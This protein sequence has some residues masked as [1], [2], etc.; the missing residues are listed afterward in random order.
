MDGD[1]AQKKMAEAIRSA[2]KETS[3]R[4]R[5]AGNPQAGNSHAIGAKDSP[6]SPP[7]WQRKPPAEALAADPLR[8]DGSE[9][10]GVPSVG[11][12]LDEDEAGLIMHYLDRV[13][14][15]QFRFYGSTPGE[16]G[17][18]WLLSIILR[19]KP[20][21][22]AVLGIAAYH[23]HYD[24]YYGHKREEELPACPILDHLQKHYVLTLEGL[25]QHLERITSDNK[26]ASLSHHVEVSA[27]IA[28]LISLEV[29]QSVGLVQHLMPN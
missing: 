3:N 28:L 17:R 7:K 26:T 9:R 21:Y 8:P 20:L 2:V 1:M 4:K 14:P 11:S 27:C 22:H 10:R 15:L 23:Q 29:G 5:K 18:G 16:S 6:P 24:L 19:T 12:S 25:Q 13:F